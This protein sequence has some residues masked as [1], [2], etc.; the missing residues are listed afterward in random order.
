MIWMLLGLSFCSESW[1]LKASERD[2]GGEY[3]SLERGWI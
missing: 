2:L 1:W 3:F